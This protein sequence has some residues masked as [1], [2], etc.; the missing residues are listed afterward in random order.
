[1]TAEGPDANGRSLFGGAL[2]TAGLPP[3]DYVARAVFES[4]GLTLGARARS[5]RVVAASTAP[6]PPSA[7]ALAQNLSSP[8]GTVVTTASAPAV[9]PSLLLEGLERDL[10]G[11]VRSQLSEQEREQCDQA[12]GFV[13]R[14]RNLGRGGK[15][16]DDIQQIR[17]HSAVIAPLVRR[18]VRL[19]EFMAAAEQ[20]RTGKT[21]A[22]IRTRS[23]AP[24]PHIEAA[25]RY[26]EENRARFGVEGTPLADVNERSLG[27]L[28]LIETEAAFLGG[29]D[30]PSRLAFARRLLTISDAGRLI[31]GFAEEWCVAVAGYLQG[32]FR[33]MD[34]MLH[35]DDGL[36]RFPDQ[37]EP[38]VAAGMFYELMGSA[39]VE[40][41]AKKAQ[42]RIHWTGLTMPSEFPTGDEDQYR[43]LSEARRTGLAQA[44]ALYRRALVADAGHQEAHLRLGR[45]LSLSGRS[46]AAITELRLAARSADP[47]VRYLASLFEGRV[48]E[49]EGRMDLAEACYRASSSA[50]PNCLSAGVASS[51][52]QRLTGQ[53]EAAG[54]TLDAALE[55]DAD[56]ARPDYWWD[57][58]LGAFSQQTRLISSLRLRLR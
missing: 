13:Q 49:S 44:E 39:A 46:A 29:E 27:A 5:I 14:A 58:P 47:R 3:G 28:C 8:A 56:S 25:L 2:E 50:C 33:L 16:E 17:T 43:R 7:P 52:V 22:T 35:L 6:L 55:R 9:A 26:L 10:R 30:V 53:A 4:G 18:Q 1:M 23:Q 57:Y 48:H 11:L 15:N 36:R 42:S 37:A 54:R 40:L 45:V 41:P 31:P 51:H 20:Y 38:L 21:T 32:E 12:R 34:L 24:A 19:D